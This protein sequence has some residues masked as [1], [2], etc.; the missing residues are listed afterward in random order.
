[1]PVFTGDPSHPRSQ[2]DECDE[3]C[4]RKK[5]TNF[6]STSGII[7]QLRYLSSSW[8]F[9]F[10]QHIR[11]V[12]SQHGCEIRQ[13]LDAKLQ[14]VFGQVRE[15]YDRECGTL[16]SN[17]ERDINQMNVLL[18][19]LNHKLDKSLWTS[20][21]TTTHESVS[22]LLKQSQRIDVI[23]K[24]LEYDWQMIRQS[25]EQPC[26]SADFH[27]SSVSWLL[28]ITHRRDEHSV[29]YYMLLSSLLVDHFDAE[30]VLVPIPIVQPK[31]DVVLKHELSLKD[32]SQSLR[33]VHIENKE[34]VHDGN[35]LPAPAPHHL[36]SVTAPILP[37]RLK[38]D[39]RS[40]RRLF[41]VPSLLIWFFLTLDSFLLNGS[42][43]SLSNFFFFLY[44][45]AW[46]KLSD[47]SE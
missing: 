24:N 1:M 31:T 4:S 18:Q 43:A 20:T 44:N 37:C 23:M 15:E 28:L 19:E 39:V 14:S 13:L 3:W 35:L 25:G 17:M 40:S 45:S 5:T 32:S 38:N 2:R 12:C 42:S 26:F 34:N 30:T 33:P 27:Q 9:I 7:S 36:R 41:Q 22:S 46:E 11:D 29:S 16:L 10:L 47:N 6:K 8:R 21:T